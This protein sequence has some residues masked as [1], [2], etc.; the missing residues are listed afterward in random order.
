MAA[1]LVRVASVALLL[2]TPVLGCGLLGKLPGGECK[3]LESGNF[4]AVNVSGGA[5]VK[6]KVVAFLE[7]AHRMKELSVEIEAGLIQS[8]TELGVAIGLSASDLKAEAGGGDGAEKA[9]GKVSE[10]IEGILKA[11]GELELSVAPPR[12]YANIEAMTQ[13]LAGCGAVV[14]PGKL[15]ASCQ[16]GELAGQCNGECSGSCSAQGGV[17][18]EGECQGQCNGTC[19]GKNVSGSCD[20]RCEGRCQGECKLAGSA[21]CGGTCTGSCTVAFTAPQCTGEFKPPKVDASC[22]AECTAKTAALARCEPPQVFVDAKGEASADLKKL[23]LALRAKL[24]GIVK[25]ELGIG[26]RAALAAESVVDAGA[27]L[28]GVVAD[29]GLEALGCIGAATSMAGSASASVSVSVKASA[30]VSAS[31]GGS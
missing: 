27:D 26:K 5:Q 4:A 19:N 22:H 20:G 9:C 30:S 31:A 18:C 23:A 13:C 2:S 28:A 29:A 25:V 12:C 11:G 3:A 24:P 10:R 1:T 16:G 7:A 8:C 14:E 17:A 15:E 21:K 6:G